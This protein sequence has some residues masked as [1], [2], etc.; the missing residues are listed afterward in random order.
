MTRAV[1][2]A[3]LP[4]AGLLIALVLAARLLVRWH[5][6]RCEVRRVLRLHGDQ[7]GTAQSLSFVLTLPLFVLVL[8][9]IVQVS[10][11]MIATVVVHYS[12][13]AAARSA[14]VWIPAWVSD[15]EPENCISASAIDPEAPDQVFPIVDPDSPDYGPA[16]GGLTYVVA[17]GSAK[18]DKIASAAVLACAAI[19][20]SRRT[21]PPDATSSLYSAVIEQAYRSMVS[22]ADANR[23]IPDRLANKVAYAAQATQVEIRFFHPNSE[24]PLM[25]YF[26][27]PDPAEFRFNELGWQDPVTVTVT[28]WF[29]LLGGPGRILARP[30]RRGDGQPDEVSARIT[31]LGN[32]YVTPITASVTLTPEGHKPAIRFAQVL[33]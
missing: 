17:P 26:E 24:P 30:V 28:H 8:L 33:E 20:P 3:I 13:Y 9:F 29:A 18:Y 5:G 15:A 7:L 22:G 1:L 6:A 25:T 12:A 19:S 23:R 2:V 10:Q 27:P 16:E 21:V 31:R 4:W 32:T 11:L 14:V